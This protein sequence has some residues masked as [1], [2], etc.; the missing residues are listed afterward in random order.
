MPSYITII[1]A[2]LFFYIFYFLFLLVIM[3]G[4]ISSL[5]QVI[6]TMKL[7]CCW[8][9]NLPV[10]NFI[11]HSNAFYYSGWHQCWSHMRKTGMGAHSTPSWVST[12]TSLRAVSILSTLMMSFLFFFCFNL[13]PFLIF[14]C[15]VIDI[16]S[17]KLYKSIFGLA[18]ANS[19]NKHC[20]LQKHFNAFAS[21]CGYF[22]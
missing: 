2:S 7:C 21:K 6:G 9:F 14:F 5:P 12:T 3:L 1:N 11:L 18:Y 19:I 15:L 22:Y 4:F 17:W 20:E 16:L 8:A 13:N 10:V